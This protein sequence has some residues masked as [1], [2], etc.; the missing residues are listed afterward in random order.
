[1]NLEMGC[2]CTVENLAALKQMD[3]PNAELSAG[4]IAQLDEAEFRKT[5]SAIESSGVKCMA[6]NG[7]VSDAVIPLFQDKR[8]ESINAYLKKLM[9]RLQQI[10]IQVAVFGS[11]KYRRAPAGT[12][13]AV[14]HK[15]I[16]E[17]L[18]RMAAI[19]A[20]YSVTVA[21]EPLNRQET[22]VLN[23]TAEAMEYIR[24]LKNDN[25]RLLI[26]LFHFVREQEDFSRIF[27][28]RDSIRH[29]HLANPFNRRFPRRQDGYDYGRFIGCLRQ[30]GYQRVISVEAV[31][32]NFIKDLDDARNIVLPCLR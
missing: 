7:L 17:L 8:F 15:R 25:L 28:F 31:T 11:G 3:I 18:E 13:T 30:A 5:R 1:M 29:V 14:I 24:L 32:D 9:P 21:V 12:D 23:T 19:A 16:A 26:D 22:N 4:W 10:G 6:C 2:C 20:R 27:A